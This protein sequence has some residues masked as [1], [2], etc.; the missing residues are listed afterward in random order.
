M[1]AYAV[2][3]LEELD[4]L[5]PDLILAGYRAGLDNDPDYSQSDRA[6]WH[7]FLNGQVDKG[8]LKPSPEQ[9]VLARA[10]LASQMS[11]QKVDSVRHGAKNFA[12]RSTGN[13]TGYPVN[14]S[15]GGRHVTA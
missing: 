8:H 10:Y 1:G 2:T 5:D 14:S 15:Y 4:A 11:Q 13:S 7:G 9:A 3:T 6:Y 12:P